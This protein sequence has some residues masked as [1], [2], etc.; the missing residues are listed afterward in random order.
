MPDYPFGQSIRSISHYLE[1]GL[2]E[3]NNLGRSFFVSYD[4]VAHFV[5]GSFSEYSDY[6]M[7]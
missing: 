6:Y 2:C 4:P 1:A 5:S 7:H 3:H